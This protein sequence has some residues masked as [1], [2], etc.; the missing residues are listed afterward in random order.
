M[1]NITTT[2]VTNMLEQQWAPEFSLQANEERIVTR[3]FSD[4][5]GGVTKIGNLLNINKVTAVTSQTLAGTADAARS[6]LTFTTNT[7]GAAVTVSPTRY[8]NGYAI[9][10]NVQSRLLREPK[11]RAALKQQMTKGLAASIDVLGANLMNAL[12]TSIVGGVG[13]NISK[14]LL[15]S[16]IAK[17]AYNAREYYS[18]MNRNLAYLCVWPLQIDDVLNIDAIT[19]AEIRGDS[20]NPN[21]SGWVWNAYGLEIAE[22]RNILTGGGLA[23]NVLHVPQSHVIAFNE[24]PTLLPELRSGMTVYAIATT[25]VGVAELWDEYAV[26]IQTQDT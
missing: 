23:Y 16:A 22:S 3:H 14:S 13:Q 26:S 8:Y 24:E 15:L 18:P 19:S 11:Y 1:A 10:R 5:P 17:L 6:D 9:T 25:E 20:Q 12:T 21:V 2:Q 7:E 4:P